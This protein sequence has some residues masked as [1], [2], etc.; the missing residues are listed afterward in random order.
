M[1]SRR[2][3]HE[4][5]TC[6]VDRPRCRGTAGSE[7]IE[8][9]CSGR[10][11]TQQNPPG[12]RRTLGRTRLKHHLPRI[13]AAA[14]IFAWQDRAC[15]RAISTHCRSD[16]QESN[17]NISMCINSTQCGQRH[18]EPLSPQMHDAS[19]CT[20]IGHF[21][22]TPAQFVV[23]H[24]AAARGSIKGNKYCNGAPALILMLAL[25]N[26]VKSPQPTMNAN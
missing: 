21:R 20:V 9:R 14:E 4:Q 11:S 19:I 26:A 22:A 6:A 18:I 8:K 15:H 23:V 12:F 2:T 1:A 16:E 17:S 13:P 5:S 24:T 3:K 25:C 10:Q 7:Y